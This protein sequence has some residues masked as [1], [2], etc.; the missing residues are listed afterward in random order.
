MTP[1][2]RENE[3]VRAESI[4]FSYSDAP[5]PALKELN[6]SL[7]KLEIHFLIG[8][9]G[10]G[11]TTLLKLLAGLYRPN[12]GEIFI[13]GIPIGKINSRERQ[14]ILKRTAMTFQRSGL[15]DSMTVFEN[16]L[17]PLKE[18]KA[19][20]LE[21]ASELVHQILGRVE[22]QG[23]EDRYPFEISGGM[24]KRLGIARALVLQPE[25]VFYDDPTAG[26]DP[27]TS[28]NIVD[29]ILDVHRENKTATL[30]A[31]SDIDLALGISKRVS[32]KISFLYQGKILESGSAEELL[33]SSHPL[34]HQF[35]HGL[36]EGPLAK[37]SL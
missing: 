35:T 32:A 13:H 28:K 30:I 37:G 15:F 27:I 22:L 2:I 34:V 18:L 11:K 6:L 1:S 20:N 24:Q 5:F 17:F 8:P 14:H 26:L 9:S 23:N 3:V 7:N 21:K 19:L 10:M 25:V 31:T 29:L 16:L 12:E 33:A 4:T 36:L